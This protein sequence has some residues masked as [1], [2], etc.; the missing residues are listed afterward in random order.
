MCWRRARAGSVA[1]SSAPPART[2]APFEEQHEGICIAA[3]TQGTFQYRSPQGSAVLAP[4][5]LLLGN[6]GT[7]FE[8]GHEH[9]TGDRCLSFHF[10]PEHLEAVVAAVPGARRT[11][12]TRPASAA[13]A[14]AA[15]ADR[16]GRSRARRWRRRCARGAC[17][18]PRRCGRD[19]RSPAPTDGA[20]R[21]AGATSGASPPRCAGSRREAHEPLSLADLAREAAMSPYHFLRTF[22]QLVGMTPHQFVL[23]TRLHRAAV[24][25]RRSDERSRRSPSTPASTTCRPSIGAFGA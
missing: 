23:R 20:E 10:T 4:G 2:T 13:A 6:A 15:A 24:R 19:R 16:R 5:A 21:R 22:R 3:V 1:T 8:C 18:A 25:L 17:A 11:A 7:C 14:R 12:F 9:G